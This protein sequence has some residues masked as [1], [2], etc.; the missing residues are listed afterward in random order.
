MEFMLNNCYHSPE[1]KTLC[2]EAFEF[3]LKTKVDFIYEKKLIVIGELTEVLKDL[4]N[5]N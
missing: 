2:Q 1:Y 3:F 5:L 4:N